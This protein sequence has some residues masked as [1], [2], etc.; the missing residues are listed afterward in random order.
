MYW[1]FE[2]LTEP[3]V[4]FGF[5]GQLVFM[6]RF[7]VQWFASERRGRSY[8]PIAFWYIS[9]A[10]GF[11]LFLYGLLDKD[12]VIMFGQLL[13]LIIYFRNLYLIYRRR[14]RVQQ[15]SF[16]ADQAAGGDSLPNL[17][18]DPSPDA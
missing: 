16:A 1:L 3:L 14:A 17:T 11:M 5:A 18:E 8:V 13:G 12:P 4:I 10:G 6:L 9:I 2:R 7:L 15:R